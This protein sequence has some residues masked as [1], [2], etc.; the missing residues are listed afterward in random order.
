MFD[1]LNDTQ[2]A[3]FNGVGMT[4][5]NTNNLN[6]IRSVNDTEVKKALL[7]AFV[8]EQRENK[9]GEKFPV[10]VLTKY[11]LLSEEEK[12]MLKT[13]NVQFLSVPNIIPKEGKILVNVTSV[14]KGLKASA[15][16]VNEVA[17]VTGLTANKY[18]P[19]VYD[20][21]NVGGKLVYATKPAKESTLSISF[22]DKR[23][24]ENG[25]LQ[26]KYLVVITRDW[27]V[28]TVEAFETAPIDFQEII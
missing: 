9:N 13:A 25:T 22:N 2:K 10:P 6:L 3:Q 12:A 5:D 14:Y 24:S 7:F 28:Q 17:C 21:K 19:P 15:N 8:T 11:M 18:F 27:Q 23:F 1:L 20:V 26:A 4:E 16:G